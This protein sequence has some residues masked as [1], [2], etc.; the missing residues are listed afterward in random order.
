MGVIFFLMGVM[1]LL[2][3]VDF[4]M[5]M[6]RVLFFMLWVGCWGFGVDFFEWMLVIVEKK[7]WDND[8]LIFVVKGN[9][10]DLGW[11]RDDLIDYVIC[12]FSILGMICG[13]YYWVVVLF[14]VRWCFWLRGI[15]VLY[16]YNYWYNLF[17]LFGLW[18][19]I[20]NWI[21]FCFC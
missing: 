19:L 10:V 8:L 14:Y 2:L 12:L 21:K 6:G 4:G 20:F 1:E 16:V 9:L 13:Y 5:G 18:W 3:I 17:D 11:L 7:V 15:F